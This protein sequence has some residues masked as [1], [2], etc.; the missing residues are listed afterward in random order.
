MIL[1]AARE[2]R[3]TLEL[4]AKLQGQLKEQIVINL[5]SSP[6]YAE[7]REAILEAV[8]PH[9]EAWLSLSD[10]MN[11]FQARYDDAADPMH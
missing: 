3:P 8:K 4:L 5:A 7:L 9:H 6:Q 2:V 11:E 1:R 10:A